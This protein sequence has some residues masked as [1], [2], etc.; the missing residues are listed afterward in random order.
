M[1]IHYSELFVYSLLPLFVLFIRLPDR[2]VYCAGVRPNTIPTTKCGL[3]YKYTL[4][5][6][7]NKSTWYTFLEI[8]LAYQV[9]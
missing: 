3:L 6:V 1:Q 8:V 5:I 2:T 7:T 4:G 9:A